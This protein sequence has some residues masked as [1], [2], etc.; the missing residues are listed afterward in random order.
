MGEESR[1]QKKFFN[2]L[3]SKPSGSLGLKPVNWL[4]KDKKVLPASIIP[5]GYKEYRERSLEPL[6]LEK[7]ETSLNRDKLVKESSPFRDSSTDSSNSFYTSKN[8]R[9]TVRDPFKKIDQDIK[10]K[11]D[12]ESRDSRT[13]D[14][15]RILDSN[16]N[17]ISK[18]LVRD[19]DSPRFKGMIKISVDGFERSSLK[20][21]S[22]SPEKTN[23]K[24]SP[25]GRGFV[26]NSRNSSLERRFTRDI[27]SSPIENR[28]NRDSQNRE[29]RDSKRRDN[30]GN[31]S[32]EDEIEDES[33]S[34]KRFLSSPTSNTFTDIFNNSDFTRKKP[35]TKSVILPIAKASKLRERLESLNDKESKTEKLSYFD[36]LPGSFKDQSMTWKDVNNKDIKVKLESKFSFMLKALWTKTKVRKSVKLSRLSFNVDMTNKFIYFAYEFSPI[37]GLIINRFTDFEKLYFADDCFIIIL[38]TGESIIAGHLGRDQYLRDFFE[39]NPV[40]QSKPNFNLDQSEVDKRKAL[41][42]NSINQLTDI[43]DSEEELSGPLTRALTRE[44]PTSRPTRARTRVSYGDAIEIG[45]PEDSLVRREIPPAFTPPLKYTFENGK[46]FTITKSD[47]K[48][49]YNNDWINDSMIDFFIQYEIDLAL[50]NSDIFK[51]NEIHPFNSFFFTK[52]ITKPD[53]NQPPPYYNNI[54]RWLNK[55]DLMS[56]PYVI[57]PINE[58]LHWYCCIIRGLPDLLDYVKTNEKTLHSEY[59]PDTNSEITNRSPENSPGV[60][61]SNDLVSL[62]SDKKY[63]HIYVFDSLGHRHKNIG[64]PLKSF[65]LEYCK[66]KYDIEIPDYL[67]RVVNAKVPK[68]NN[69]NDCGLHVIFNV[70]KWL[71]YPFDLEKLWRSRSRVQTSFRQIFDASERDNMRTQLQEIMINLHKEQDIV[72]GGTSEA[73]DDVEVIELYEEVKKD[74]P[75]TKGADSSISNETLVSRLSH[76]EDMLEIERKLS[77]SKVDENITNEISKSNTDSYTEL[78]D[79]KID[80]LQSG[81]KS[82]DFSSA[83]SE[84]SN[85]QFPSTQN[86]VNLDESLSG[87]SNENSHE[88]ASHFRKHSSDELY[89]SDL[90]ALGENVVQGKSSLV[91][92]NDMLS[93]SEF[94][95]SDQKSMDDGIRFHAESFRGSEKSSQSPNY[96]IKNV[97]DDSA[98]CSKTDELFPAKFDGM[99]EHFSRE[100]SILSFDNTEGRSKGNDDISSKLIASL[101]RDDSSEV[102]SLTEFIGGNNVIRNDEVNTSDE[103]VERTK[104]NLIAESNQSEEFSETPTDED[105][106]VTHNLDTK[107]IT[108]QTDLILP[109]SE[110]TEPVEVESQ[111]MTD[112]SQVLDLHQKGSNE[113]LNS[114]LDGTVIYKPFA[115]QVTERFEEGEAIST[116]IPRIESL[117]EKRDVQ[118]SRRDDIQE[119]KRDYSEEKTPVS[120]QESVS[121]ESIEVGQTYSTLDPRANTPTLK[122]YSLEQRFSTESMTPRVI[123]ELNNI[124]NK[125]NIQ[126]SQPELKLVSSY[127]RDVT[128]GNLRRL[129]RKLKADLKNIVTSPL[130]DFVINDSDDD[131]NAIELI[132]T[133]PSKNTFKTYKSKNVKNLQFSSD[134]SPIASSPKRRRVN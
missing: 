40:W 65:I 90:I 126:L 17:D 122:N 80:R 60:L 1:G 36:L 91:G 75:N 35:L 117:D 132:N 118:E 10:R 54:K 106:K 52:L 38:K 45:D 107:S 27:K 3:R 128:K 18:S 83:G 88:S 14:I 108:S 62:E 82:N 116:S 33:D 67:L 16:R 87:D 96:E 24:T 121:V 28:D 133:N 11:R 21:R 22:I 98:E 29:S 71:R 64:T 12:G 19:V 26:K 69:F 56:F 70:R 124:F 41:M 49:L 73:E 23:I 37:N 53:H 131:T 51:P 120:M 110:N 5:G 48:T 93:S 39:A 77:E 113:V 86:S 66:D 84:I 92:K 85:D 13:L 123:Q 55:F 43:K 57:M 97:D 76:E 47:F 103:V 89:D 42:R 115:V 74:V 46:S 104:L 78:D 129:T 31:I 130:L 6:D 63:A 20:S 119:R 105:T 30:G 34:M 114:I 79:I 32:F 15:S 99:D 127:I 100:D 44:F 111:D 2:S 4:T 8:S 61:D 72:A 50:K 68:Q 25:I 58:N 102:D 112:Y 9:K 81:S 59:I 95:D 101:A 94:S 134:G 109:S 7:K 125:T